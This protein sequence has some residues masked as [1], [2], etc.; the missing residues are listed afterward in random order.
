MENE[1]DRHEEIG[2]MDPMLIA[3]QAPKR[4]PLLDLVVELTGRS[5]GFFRSLP[6]EIAQSLARLV[7]SMNCYYSN[8]IEGHDT[9]P[10]DIERALR[11]DY[12]QDVIK[13]NLQLEAEAHIAVQ[14][15]IDGGGLPADHV[16]TTDGIREIHRR[17]C[18]RLP[19][20]LLWVD[21]PDGDWRVPIQPGCYRTTDVQVGRHLAIS[22]G[23]IPRFM[24]RFTQ[25]YGR[26]GPAGRI[27]SA[28]AAHHRL[29]WIHP[30]V[31]GN[32]R[33]ARLL[34]YAMLFHSVQNGGLWSI[35][36]GLARNQSEYFRH[37]ANCDLKRRNDL[38]GRGTLSQEALIDF[39]EF[40]LKTCIDQ[41]QFMESLVQPAGL[42]E[43][44]LGWARTEMQ[45]GRLPGHTDRILEALLYRGQMERGDIPSLLSVQDRQ[46]RRI[47]ADLMAH[48]L[49]V[50]DSPRAPLRLAFPARLA[51][52][53]LPG[54][55]PDLPQ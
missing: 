24:E 16:M 18:D 25:A 51:S 4:G 36:R 23:A 5:A 45:Q 33:V 35:A 38:D 48:D 14:S 37:L 32:G 53:W 8:L 42:R 46:A 44:I 55:F 49:L 3:E 52:S 2:L 19:P 6:N 29:V 15:W 39:T 31:D 12:S 21:S 34:S 22:A 26:L 1:L 50:S 28:A 43:R 9:H 13:R 7:R 11:G 17:F 20:E 30:F 10:V 40:F 54:L 27:L 47:T 41:V